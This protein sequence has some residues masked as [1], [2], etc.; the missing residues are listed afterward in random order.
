MKGYFIVFEGSDGSGKATQAALLLKFLRKKRNNV[1]KIEFPQYGKKSAGLIEN[2][3][4]GEYG[5]SENV[6]PYTASIFYACDRY[7]ASFKIKKW[8]NQGYIV[9]SDRYTSSSA[10]HQ[11]GKIE[12]KKE[13]TRYI[14]WLYDLE[15][16]IL[17]LPKPNISFILKT[18]PEFSYK[19]SIKNKN[20]KNSK[21]LSYLGNKKRDIHEKDKKHLKNT[22]DSYDE[23]AKKYPHEFKVINC[24]SDE[25]L[26]SPDII[27]QEIIKNINL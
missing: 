25:K 7:D 24:I 8:L 19:L 4:K 14:K 9:I 5:S 1:K 23:L 11:G 17:K 21:G 18:T 13:R 3:L 2:Y 10:G 22:I 12:D 20:I 16:N 27:H 6:D 26:L 15:Y